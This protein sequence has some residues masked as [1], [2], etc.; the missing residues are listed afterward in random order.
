M[1]QTVG[2]RRELLTA[3]MEDDRNMPGPSRE[4]ADKLGIKPH[5]MLYRRDRMT[6][7]SAWT[8]CVTATLS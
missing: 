7:R 5:N 4:L 6:P 8:A 1:P 3:L 2:Y